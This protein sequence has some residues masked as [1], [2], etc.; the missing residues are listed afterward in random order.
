MN[1]RI[2]KF[3]RRFLLAT[4]TLAAL[5]TGCEALAESKAVVRGVADAD[6]RA[7][8]ET[9]VGEVDKPADGAFQARRRAAEAAD[10]A[11]ATLRSEGYYAYAVEPD[12]TETDPPKAV[13]K[14]TAGPRFRLAEP[15]LDWLKAPSEPTTAAAALKAVGLK[16]GQAGRAADVL[17]A[18]GRV[19]AVLA[20]RGYPDAQAG[21]RRVVVDHAA[22]TVQ[23]T[24]RIDAGPLV[25]LDGIQLE[26][27][28]RTRAGWVA[29]LAPW[30]KGE[31]YDPDDVAELERRLVETGVYESV[32]VSLAPPD[33]TNAAGERPVIVGLADRA[34]ATLEIGAGYSTSEGASFDAR[35]NRYNRLGRADTLTAYARLAQ[36]DQRLALQLQL[37][38]WRQ[39]ARTLT[40]STEA[41]N[42]Q[43]DAYDRTGAN[44]RADLKKR[45]QKTSLLTWGI[46]LEASQNHEVVL[47]GKTRTVS[48]I[49]RNLVILTG[50]GGLQL[51]RSNDLLDPARGWRLAL[52][53]QPTEVAGDTQMQFLRALAQV[54]AY[55][56]VQ[57]KGQSVVSGR[58]KLGVIL[59]GAFPDAPA[60]RRFY[61]GGGGSVRG[62]EYQGIGPRLPNKQPEG[63]LSLLETSVEFRHRLR[64]SLEGAVFLDAGAVGAHPGF[65]FADVRAGV[66]FGVRYHLPF[67]PLRADIAF[68]LDRANGQ[69][70]FQIYLGIGQ[71]F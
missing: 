69:A 48:P 47:V 45:F 41:F 70:P 3:F 35:L 15:R 9:A 51:D 4:L 55:L 63:G 10:A 19:V 44:V 2:V 25:R 28:G 62:Y 13:V 34:R 32:T 21:E 40:L 12:V 29:S 64:G 22:V 60:D 1:R 31:R 58:L 52:D 65:D 37:P 33:K 17:A 36:I 39:P 16:P 26:S 14:I 23:P 38:H 27:K 8:I 57:D 56:P 59:N 61:A 67:G 54:T 18:E 68:P 30:R 42:E 71:A 43:T 6:L 53:V 46:G 49:E 7:R 24:Y 11:I 50:Y 20:E 66:G 5:L